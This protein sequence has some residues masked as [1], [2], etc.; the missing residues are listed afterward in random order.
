M[1]VLIFALV[2]KMPALLVTLPYIRD[3]GSDWFDNIPPV[4]KSFVDWLSEPCAFPVS[5]KIKQ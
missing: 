1:A 2:A 5:R 4:W 3:H